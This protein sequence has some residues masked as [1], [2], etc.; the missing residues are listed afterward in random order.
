MM[1]IQIRLVILMEITVFNIRM[2]KFDDIV[3][4][5]Y[6]EKVGRVFTY[7]KIGHKVH[8]L[9]RTNTHTWQSEKWDEM[10]CKKIKIPLWDMRIPFNIRYNRMQRTPDLTPMSN[11]KDGDHIMS[12]Y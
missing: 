11:D 5:S 4:N 7:D 10:M 3:K 9:V 12:L 2:F 1:I 6:N 8:V